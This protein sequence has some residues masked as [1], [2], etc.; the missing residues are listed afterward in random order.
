MARRP[1]GAPLAVFYARSLDTWS[2]GAFAMWT[3][4]AAF[5]MKFFQR[6]RHRAVKRRRNPAARARLLQEVMDPNKSSYST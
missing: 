5:G 6:G 2:K 1:S 4:Y 3:A